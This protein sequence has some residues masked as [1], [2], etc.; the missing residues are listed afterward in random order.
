[1]KVIFGLFRILGISMIVLAMTFLLGIYLDH[2][3]QFRP[4][5]YYSPVNE[6]LHE[7]GN[8][9][10]KFFPEAIDLKG[11][12]DSKLRAARPVFAPAAYA[13]VAAA[14]VAMIAATI[15]NAMLRAKAQEF[16]DKAKEFDVNIRRRIADFTHVLNQSKNYL[17]LVNEVGR[18]AQ[19]VQ[20]E[21]IH[22]RGHLKLL[23]EACVATQ[24]S[25]ATTRR[26]A[27]DS[28]RNWRDLNVE[29]SRSRSA[30]KDINEFSRE[31]A[32]M[33]QTHLETEG[34]LDN[35]AR[36]QTLIK[37]TMLSLNLLLGLCVVIL[38][39]LVLGW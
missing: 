9:L 28:L 18:I 2:V 17:G 16:A 35:I 37:W 23:R 19:K 32:A 29:I 30:M 14:L 33:R 6:F 1:M 12:D 21:L 10:P 3:L 25:V 38:T 31:L 4:A 39:T 13:G 5:N 22:F 8:Y 26:G 27:D 15:N 34:R 36:N 24:Q 20:P 7:F 11:V